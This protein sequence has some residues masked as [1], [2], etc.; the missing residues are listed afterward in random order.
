MSS[1]PRI[2]LLLQLILHRSCRGL[3][4]IG[5]SNKSLE[6][7]YFNN[8]LS[9]PVAM[10]LHCGKSTKLTDYQL[11]V[12]LKQGCLFQLTYP[13]N[14]PSSIDNHVQSAWYSGSLYPG[15]RQLST[16][17]QSV[18]VPKISKYNLSMTFLTYS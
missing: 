12:H 11:N 1:W 17:F 9:Q 3:S 16:E 7:P 14:S 5:T 4:C 15:G 6:N 10:H 8:I 2:P 18:T 13:K